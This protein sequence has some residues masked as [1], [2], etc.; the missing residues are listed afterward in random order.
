MPTDLR[1]TE[2]QAE[3]VYRQDLDD[4][5]NYLSRTYNWFNNLDDNKKTAVMSY[6]YNRGVLPATFVQAMSSG[7]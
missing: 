1:W 4:R 2:E 7:D 6:Y 5:Y 3:Q